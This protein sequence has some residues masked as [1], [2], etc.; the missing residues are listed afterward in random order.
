MWGQ[1]KS[2]DASTAKQRIIPTRVGTREAF[3]LD[4]A[5]YQDHPHACGDKWIIVCLK[6]LSAGSSPRVWGQAVLSAVDFG[7]QGII[8]T[9]V[10][11]SRSSA[12]RFP[13]LWDHPHACGDKNVIFR[14]HTERRGSSPRVWGQV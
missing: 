11:T 5:N 2:V 12:Q 6:L 13:C 1:G 3:C 9:R 8:P 10:G 14:K 4:N 7:F